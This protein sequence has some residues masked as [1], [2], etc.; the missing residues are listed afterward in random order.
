[1]V[2]KK[3]K[4]YNWIKILVYAGLIAVSL[5]CIYLG[6]VLVKDII[7]DLDNPEI[8]P[9]VTVTKP[10]FAIILGALIIGLWS[11]TIKILNF[12]KS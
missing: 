2:T 5:G 11:Q 1:M 10:F 7:I 12:Y 9:Y 3:I 8:D 6:Y 4:R